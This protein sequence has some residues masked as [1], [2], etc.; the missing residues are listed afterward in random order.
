MW[1]IYIPLH[2]SSIGR[3]NHQNMYP[4]FQHT[5]SERE[6]PTH[7]LRPRYSIPTT[8]ILISSLPQVAFHSNHL[9]TKSNPMRVSWVLG[10]LSFEAQEQGVHHWGSPGLGGVRIAGLPSSAELSSAGLSSSSTRLQDYED[11]RLKT[12]SRVRMGLSLAWK[13]SLAIRICRS[14]TIVTDFV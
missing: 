7:V 4:H 14:P 12:S 10:R 8:R 1:R 3:E 6:P 11:T 2:P 5:F 9:S 13:A